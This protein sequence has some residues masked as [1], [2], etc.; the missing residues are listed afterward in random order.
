VLV[1]DWQVEIPLHLLA[2]SQSVPSETLVPLSE[3][4]CVPVGPHVVTP[5]WHGLAGLQVIPVVQAAQV[6]PGELPQQSRPASASLAA[7][8]PQAHAPV[9]QRLLAPLQTVPQAPQLPWSVWMSTSQPF[10]PSLSQLRWLA[11]QVTTHAIAAG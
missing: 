8:P 9:T 4:V 6:P 7:P 2:S 3:Q 5:P 10:V 11:V 1:P